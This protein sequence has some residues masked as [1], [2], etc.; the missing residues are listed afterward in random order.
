[1]TV[2]ETFALIYYL[3]SSLQAGIAATDTENGMT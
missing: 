3:N 1:M 2:M